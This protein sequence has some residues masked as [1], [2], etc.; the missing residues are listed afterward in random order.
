MPSL[1]DPL[2]IRSVTFD[3]R[4]WVSPMC[5]Y[6]ARDGVAGDWHQAHIGALATGG[7][8]LIM[9]EA[10]GVV[11][12]G[13][14]SINCLGL[15]NDQQEAALKP[16]VDFAHSMGRKIGI[17]LAHAGRKGSTYAPW[18]PTL[19][20]PPEAGGWQT[21][22]SSPIA[23]GQMPI[24]R[25]LSID[26]IRALVK[27]FAEAAERAV[28]AGF[29]L[30]EIHAAHGYLINQFTSPLVNKRTDEY[31]GNFE[32]RTRFFYEIVE[33]IR[34]HIPSNMPLF[35]RISAIDWVDEGWSIKDS[36]RLA[37]DLQRLGVDLIDTSSGGAVAEAKITVGPG[38]Q[39]PFAE[40]IKKESSIAT[41]SVGFIT[42]P[43][44]ADEIVKSGKADAVMIGRLMLRNPRWPFEAARALKV[45]VEWPP[46]LV[47]GKL[48]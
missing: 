41:A 19:I 48:K 14:I 11:P 22:S 8:G 28:R 9:M 42:E 37:K 10:T 18:G 36:I 47:R 1:F 38:Y 39:V 5:Q 25:E 23:F 12:E 3:N 21:V 46:Q 17:Q 6:S 13:R 34:A 29:D 32:G 35:A 20:A 31:G 4:I 16:L 33:S 15:W 45:D 26:E 40:A 43:E 7:A 2:T 44:Q 27:S 24:P 30:V